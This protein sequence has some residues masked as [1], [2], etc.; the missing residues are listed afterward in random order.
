MLYECSICHELDLEA[1]SM[2]VI[3][4]DDNNHVCNECADDEFDEEE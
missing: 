1:E 3:D 4:E 2:A